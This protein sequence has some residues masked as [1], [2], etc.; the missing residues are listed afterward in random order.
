MSNNLQVMMKTSNIKNEGICQTLASGQFYT[1]LVFVYIFSA[2]LQHESIK[3]TL[4]G[5][6]VI[7][8]GVL[9]TLYD[10]IQYIC[11]LKS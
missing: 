4:S 5:H 7:I 3:C 1:V 2:L 11:V 10:T 8:L 9:F 6:P